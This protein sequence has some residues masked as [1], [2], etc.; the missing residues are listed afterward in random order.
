[1]WI[2]NDDYGDGDD[3]NKYERKK[4]KEGEKEYL[5]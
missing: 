5:I 2:W 3:D 4:N 1:M